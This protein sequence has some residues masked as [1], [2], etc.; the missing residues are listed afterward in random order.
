MTE[1][2][3]EKKYQSLSH[4]LGITG[5]IL[6]IITLLVSFIP[7]FGVFAYLI[8]IV[9]ILISLIGLGI[10][11]KFNHAKGLLIGA[12]ITAFIGCGIAYSQYSAMKGTVDVMEQEM[13]KLEKEAENN[14]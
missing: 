14:K 10:A 3:Q 13:E 6:G 2:L 8:G 12:L 4:G 5:L 9:A 1:K 11:M 7:C